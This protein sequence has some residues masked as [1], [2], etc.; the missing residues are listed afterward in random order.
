MRQ[1]VV[2]G[3]GM[4]GHRLVE[5]VLSRDTDTPWHITV[6]GEEPRPAY[7]RVALSSYFDG[8][9]EEE[10]RLPQLSDRPGVETLLGESAAA[11]DRGARTVTT[12][13]GRVL[14][15]DALVLATGS[16]AFV[17]PV[18]G[19]DLPGCHTYRTIDDLVDV[20]AT[21][22]AA[23]G[24]GDAAGVV[25]GGGLLGLEAA[26]ALKLLGM[27]AHVVEMAPWLMPRQVDEGG[28]A[29]L[30]RLIA[31]TGVTCHTAAGLAGIEPAPD[32]AG[33]RVLLGEQGPDQRRID[34]G[35]VVFSVGVRPR[36]ELAR[37]A[38]LEIGPRGGVAIDSTCRT[39]DPRIYA[40]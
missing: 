16:S 29:V 33:L 5:A 12:S 22:A 21:A 27:D 17:P 28:G 30:G 3:N 38:G 13:T 4:V 37:A 18:P 1:L 40:V 25:V 32:G 36:D 31:E 7:D 34:A 10:L 35:I 2:I 11:L 39:S 24:R 15:Y 26:N 19:R 14:T 20:A 23:T 8:A 9:G 6:L